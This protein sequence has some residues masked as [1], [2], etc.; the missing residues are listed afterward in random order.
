M[1]SVAYNNK[2]KIIIFT[3]ATKKNLKK[4]FVFSMKMEHHS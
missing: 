1:E 4:N 3:I 2:K